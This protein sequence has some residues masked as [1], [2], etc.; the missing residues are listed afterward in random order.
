MTSLR[1]W[2][3]ERL[4]PLLS[5]LGPIPHAAGLQI[6]YSSVKVADYADLVDG[7]MMQKFLKGTSSAFGE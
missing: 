7:T 3:P 5:A 1:W 4:R 6:V 2:K